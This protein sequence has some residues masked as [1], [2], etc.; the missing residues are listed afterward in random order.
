MF[1]FFLLW[2]IF[3][4]VVGVAAGARG[5]NGFGWFL[6][7]VILS[8]LIGLILVFAMPNKRAERIAAE[9]ATALRAQIAEQQAKS[10]V[11]PITLETHTRCPDC[12]EWVRRDATVCKHCHRTLEPSPPPA[13]PPAGQVPGKP[14]SKL[15]AD[16]KAQII[17]FISVLAA[18]LAYIYLT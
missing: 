16:T 3:A 1:E 9:Q 14:Q 2:L 10:G 7:A 17:V 4:I 18:I 5:R 15:D 6:I 13:A 8:P 12:K 11:E